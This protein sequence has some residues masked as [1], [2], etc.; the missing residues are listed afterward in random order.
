MAR[1]HPHLAIKPDTWVSL[2]DFLEA[3][4]QPYSQPTIAALLDRWFGYSLGGA[5]HSTEV[6]TTTGAHVDLKT[7][8][9]AIQSN[10][11]CRAGL[12]EAVLRLRK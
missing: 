10:A 7:L 12:A 8:Y 6:L 4:R 2:D 3:I 1:S 9:Q 5:H 11:L